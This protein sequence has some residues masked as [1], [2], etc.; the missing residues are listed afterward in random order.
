MTTPQQTAKMERMSDTAV[1]YPLTSDGAMPGKCQLSHGSRRA[2][3][4]LYSG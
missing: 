3:F 4:I 1:V 2:H